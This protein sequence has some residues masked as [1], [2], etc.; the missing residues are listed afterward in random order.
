[1]NEQNT[2]TGM[3]TRLFSDGNLADREHDAICRHL[4]DE[5]DAGLRDEALMEYFGTQ[6]GADTFGMDDGGE[7]LIYA[8]R[9]RY[10]AQSLG[11]D[12][13]LGRLVHRYKVSLVTWHRWRR[14]VRL[15]AAVLIPAALFVGT[16][17]W[18]SDRL[19]GPRQELSSAH[20]AVSTDAFN[21]RVSADSVR[22]VAL[23][24]GTVVTLNDG[25][26]LA[27]NDRREARLTGEAFFEVASD[28]ERPF[29]I[30]SDRLTVRVLGT[31]FI[32]W[33][34]T[35]TSGL[36]L[37]SGEVELSSDSG[38]SKLNGAGQ[39]FTLDHTTGAASVSEFDSSQLPDWASGE[40]SL[41]IM[42]LGEILDAI[43]SAYGVHFVGRERIDASR[44]YNF[45]LNTSTPLP[46]VMTALEFLNKD[47]SYRIEGTQ[48]VLN[49]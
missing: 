18:G 42:T 3:V 12:P 17:Y 11:F 7:E 35:G 6:P 5:A 2:I 4:A 44:R 45:R 16:F 41:A 8:V 25:A 38:V 40:S 21:H 33:S 31:E 20:R 15:A 1:M 47:F 28:T 27:Y 43:E 22:V 14:I 9:W 26:L 46:D 10:I 39:R 29:T 48:I 32:F 37:Y 36:S 30:F 49:P 23:S 19:Q 13:D 24:D 34:G